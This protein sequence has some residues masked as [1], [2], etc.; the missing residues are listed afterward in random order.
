M[1]YWTENANTYRA[2]DG[3]HDHCGHIHFS[4]QSALQ[5]CL[6][7]HRKMAKKGLSSPRRVMAMSGYDQRTVPL[8]AG[9]H[10]QLRKL[11]EWQKLPE[12]A[13]KR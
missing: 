2:S 6:A 5:C 8:T 7:D 10:D 12:H 11:K 3:A 1:S 13:K 4:L 9:E